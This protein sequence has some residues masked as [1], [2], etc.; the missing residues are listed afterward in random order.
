[1]ARNDPLF[2]PFRLRVHVVTA[3]AASP[4]RTGRLFVLAL[5]V[6]LASGVALAAWSATAD[7]APP[8]AGAMLPR[9]PLLDGLLDQAQ[10]SPTQRD[11]AHQI[12]D[13]ADADL[14]ESRVAERA[15]HEQMAR[16]FAQPLVDAAAVEAV[17]SRLSQRHDLESRRA[18][19]ALI[20]VSL[21]LNA[22]QRQV[23]ASQLVDAPRAF[24][25]FH[26]PHA[27]SAAD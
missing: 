27:A 1:M 11:Q 10:A 24:D 16:L 22:S 4:S 18:T 19:Q 20:D 3:I 12:F 8:R 15:D 9:G 5:G 23:V 6:A 21:V 2:R 13:A 14:H 17:R 7:L 26:H 25:T